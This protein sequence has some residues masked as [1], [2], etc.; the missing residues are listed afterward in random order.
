MATVRAG[1]A[2][3]SGQVL[4]EYASA[5]LRK[6]AQPE[7]TVIEQLE[8]FAASMSV[9]SI[10]PH[11][12]LR[13]VRLRSRFQISYWDACIIAAA[14]QAGCETLYSEDLNA[15]QTYVGVTVQNP[16]APGSPGIP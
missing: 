6:M 8:F 5:A 14:E 4:S 15:G 2:V 3:I 7:Q 1:E 16:F 11:E 13:A 9:V 10:G 12:V